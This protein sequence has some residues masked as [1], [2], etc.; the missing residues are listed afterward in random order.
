[1]SVGERRIVTPEGAEVFNH[2][3]R[4]GFLPGIS[5]AL[6]DRAVRYPLI[7]MLFGGRLPAPCGVGSA[8][9]RLK[10]LAQMVIR[11]SGRIVRKGGVDLVAVPEVEPRG[12]KIEG[13]QERSASSD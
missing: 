6:I 13:A 11:V 9:S 3:L 5:R 10:D 8:P 1:M 4:T 7:E 12:L 2:L